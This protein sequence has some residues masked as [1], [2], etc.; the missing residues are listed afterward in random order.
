MKLTLTATT[1]E[2]HHYLS[3]AKPLPKQITP[4]KYAFDKLILDKVVNNCLA[5]NSKITLVALRPAYYQA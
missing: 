5:R 3:E 1:K 4:G 2:I